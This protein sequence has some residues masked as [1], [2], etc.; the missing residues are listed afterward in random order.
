MVGSDR[1]DVYFII[2]IVNRMFESIGVFLFVY[3]VFLVSFLVMLL[4]RRAFKK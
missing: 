4:V 1:G 2:L 3:L